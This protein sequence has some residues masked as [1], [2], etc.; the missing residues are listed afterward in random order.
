V[1]RKV[2]EDLVPLAN[3]TGPG[4]PGISVWYRCS[5][6]YA[7]DD[8]QEQRGGRGRGRGRGADTDAAWSGGGGGGG[9]GADGGGGGTPPSVVEP[10]QC[11]QA[12]EVA[13]EEGRLTI[14][15]PDDP[16]PFE[17]GRGGAQEEAP[18]ATIRGG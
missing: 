15:G 1:L 11:L 8:E 16:R 2:V 12:V 14:P 6:C 3:R 9:G 10:F 5:M 4:S 13:G 17:W 18:D 7:L